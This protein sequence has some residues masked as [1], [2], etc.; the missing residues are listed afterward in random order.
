[1]ESKT[2]ELNIL[3]YWLV[4]ILEIEIVW[5]KKFKN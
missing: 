5:R 1:M 3:E 4:R 2:E